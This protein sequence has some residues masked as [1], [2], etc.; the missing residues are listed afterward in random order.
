M[1]TQKAITKCYVLVVSVCSVTSGSSGGSYI[2]CRW[3]VFDFRS[4]IYCWYVTSSCRL[5]VFANLLYLSNEDVLDALKLPCKPLHCTVRGLIQ[6]V[7]DHDWP[8]SVDRF[9]CWYNSAGSLVG[10]STLCVVDSLWRT[11]NRPSYKAYTQRAITYVWLL[12]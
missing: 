12:D 5:L 6:K 1:Y 4:P 8:V 2:W 7:L 10:L 3:H 9:G 11:R